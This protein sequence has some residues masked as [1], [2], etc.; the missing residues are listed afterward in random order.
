MQ[1]NQSKTEGLA[2]VASSDMVRSL[3]FAC[4]ATYEVKGEPP[5]TRTGKLARLMTHAATVGVVVKPPLFRNGNTA[6]CL[7]GCPTPG[8]HRKEQRGWVG[9]NAEEPKGDPV[10]CVLCQPT[11][12]DPNVAGERLPAKNV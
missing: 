6:P 1:D 5:K 9:K 4:G 2:A 7:W 12:I 11:H 3:Y 10:M 8:R